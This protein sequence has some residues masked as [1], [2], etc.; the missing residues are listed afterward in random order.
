MAATNPAPKHYAVD[1]C[2]ARWQ[3]DPS[4][5]NMTD[6]YHATRAHALHATRRYLRRADSDVAATAATDAILALPAEL[7]VPFSAWVWRVARNQCFAHAYRQNRDCEFN[8]TAHGAAYVPPLDRVIDFNGYVQRA[9][10]ADVRLIASMLR[11]ES[12][13]EIA[14]RLGTTVPAAKGRRSRFYRRLRKE[15]A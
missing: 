11:G 9:K 7:R 13:E 2:F 3:A 5:P 15:L 8:P 10:A 12:I 14:A 6:L 1:A 4:E